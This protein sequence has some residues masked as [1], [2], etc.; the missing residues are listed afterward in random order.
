V[1]EAL[2]VRVL[3]RLGDLAQ[4]IQ[5]DHWADLGPALAHKVIKPQRLLVV[6]E[7]QSRAAVGVAIV[8]HTQNIRMLDALENLEL[9]RGRAHQPLPSL[10]EVAWA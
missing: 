10:L 6:L 1:V 7:D 5:A 3:E 8:K 4:K 9:A 2:L